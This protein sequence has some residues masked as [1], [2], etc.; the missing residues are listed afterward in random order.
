MAST[1]QTLFASGRT[2]LNSHAPPSV[3]ARVE[4]IR[5][6]GSSPGFPHSPFVVV[7]PPT[8]GRLVGNGLIELGVALCLNSAFSTDRSQPS[9]AERFSRALS[10]SNAALDLGPHFP[11][12]LPAR[13]PRAISLC[14]I[15]T[16]S[17]LRERSSF[18]A[19]LRP[20]GSGFLP[21]TVGV[22]CGGARGGGLCASACLVPADPEEGFWLEPEFVDG[23]V[24]AD[25]LGV[26]GLG[27][28]CWFQGAGALG[29]GAGEGVL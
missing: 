5:T 23:S 21:G 29:D 14:C 3:S 18:V 15:R 6:G 27:V 8:N 13:Y 9:V 11:S 12:A 17:S 25:S 10:S 28:G 22:S 7:Q 16:T 1:R 26:G 2:D 19:S 24:C 20:G 4:V